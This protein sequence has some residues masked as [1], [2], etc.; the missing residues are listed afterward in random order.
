MLGILGIAV[1]LLLCGCGSEPFI[2][3]YAPSWSYLVSTDAPA[4]ELRQEPGGIVRSSDIYAAA[5]RQQLRSPASAIVPFRDALFLL[6]PQESLVEILE[7]TSFRSRAR[8]PLPS[9]PRAIAFPNATTAVTSHPELGALQLLDLVALRPAAVLAL[10]GHLTD[11]LAVGPLLYA[12][13]SSGK[14]LLCIDLRQMAIVDSATLPAPPRFLGL[15]ADSSELLVLCAGSG[16]VPSLDSK[17]PVLL[18]FRRAPLEQLSAVALYP[19]AADSATVRLGGLVTTSG[20]FAWIGTSG[21]LLRVDIRT[22][23]NV[24]VFN[25]WDIRQLVYVRGA[26]QLWLLHRA[27]RWYVTLTSATR[28]EPQAQ[29]AFPYTV[30]AFAPLP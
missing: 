23:G 2:D 9:P 11:L 20:D 22:R 3:S 21:G 4:L 13:D 30:I 28:A 25:R 29:T 27:D 1:A 19:S 18:F 16:D 24:R 26:E 6:L 10:G 5:N 17:A 7:R 8:I 15:R 12:A 14:R